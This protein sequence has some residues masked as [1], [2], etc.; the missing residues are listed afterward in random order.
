M[1][2]LKVQFVIIILWVLNEAKE[3]ITIANNRSHSQP[4]EDEAVKGR[5]LWRQKR[6][7]GGQPLRPGEWPWL[8]SLHYLSDHIY[9]NMQG[10]KHLCGATLIHPQW[11]VT[12]AHCVHR[13]SGYRNLEKAESWVAVMGEHHRRETEDTEQRIPISKIVHHP[14]YTLSPKFTKDIA[15]LKLARPARMTRFVRPIAINKMVNLPAHTHQCRL[16]AEENQ[17]KFSSAQQRPER[18]Q[19][20]GPG[21]KV[22]TDGWS[23]MLRG[24]YRSF[25]P[26]EAPPCTALTHPSAVDRLL[27]RLNLGSECY[28]AGWGQHS[29]GDPYQPEYG[30][31]TLVPHVLRVLRVP[32]VA[33]W[34]AY[35]FS[36]P[37]IDATV[38]CYAA[39]QYGDTCKGD[40]GGP[41]LCYTDEQPVLVGVVSTG[42][43]CALPKYPGVYT[44]VSAY[45]DWIDETIMNDKD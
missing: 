17:K 38:V 39:K 9:L 3:N 19:L 27:E 22:G 13:T 37:L 30:N 11:L 34:A 12:A 44:R 29:S 23:Q 45:Y 32:Q 35:L 24:G 41:L 14:G 31:G 40:S 6:V 43:G 42:M 26:P 36:W 1:F 10:L 33:C 8:V 28:T 16:E 15:L 5:R 25:H 21:M 2:L 18:R 7:V 20:T 4:Y